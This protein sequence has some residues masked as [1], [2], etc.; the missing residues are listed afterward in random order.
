MY[1]SEEIIEEVRQ[2]NPIVDVIGS[3]VHLTKKGGNYFGLCPF[4]NEKTPSFSVAPGKQ[5]FHCF[6]CGAGG[7]VITFI[8][9]YENLTFP[10]ALEFLAKRA[11]VDLPQRE[12]T[13]EMREDEDRRSLLLRM[14]KDAA[15]YYVHMLRSP[16]GRLGLDYFRRRGLTDETIRSFGLGFAGPDPKALYR[17][18][19]DKGYTDEQMR[20]ASL[21][22]VQERGAHDFFWNRVM[23]PV[24]DV[25]NR[26]IGFGGRVM[27][28]AEPKYLNSKETRIFDKSRNLY[29]L[30]AAK[31]SRE[32][33]MLVMEGY[34][35]VISLHQAGFINAVASLG[36]AFTS[37]HGMILKRYTD[38]VVLCYDHDSAGRKAALRAIP[39]LKE[40]GLRIKVLDLSPYK[41]PDEFIKSQGADAF[42]KRISE[43]ENAFVFEIACLKDNYDFTDPDDKTAFFNEAA[44]RLTAFTDEIERNSYTEAVARKYGIDYGV[45]KSKVNLLG[46]S[47]GLTQQTEERFRP[48]SAVQTLKPKD[49]SFQE[50]QRLILTAL[51]EAPSYYGEI[52]RVLGPE[53]FTDELLSRVA[54][55]LFEQL[56]EGRPE[57]ARILDRFIDD[58]RYREAAALFSSDFTEEMDEEA[59][60]QAL[61]EAVL[62]LKQNSLERRIGKEEDPVR[63]MELLRE[64]NALKGMEILR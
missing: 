23:F 32:K 45:L 35:D 39:I 33:Y 15:L 56:R 24:M 29:G 44:R 50:A 40:A 37:Q 28:D 51:S 27:G 57:P 47:V 55:L 10:E 34:M 16:Q 61:R 20:D 7:N 25:N 64:K 52:S 36:T 58:D 21:A 42:R 41:D 49:H 1:Y 60:R 43:A 30:N 14:H 31:R 26:V 46:N 18:L 6:G 12:Y 11:G 8:M 22:T 48:K 9:D 62:H 17:Y 2:R 63:L 3:Y 5:M 59:R 54:E 38:E 53:D 19:K 4:H 13:K